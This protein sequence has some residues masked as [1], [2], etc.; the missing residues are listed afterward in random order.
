MVSILPAERTPYDV[1]GNMLGQDIRQNLPGAVA[2]GYQRGRGLSALD[3]AQA[4][5]AKNPNDPYAI[6]MAF[7]KAGAQNPE[8]SRALGPLAQTAMSQAAV[9]RAFPQGPGGQPSGGAP[10]VGGAPSAQGI[11]F[12]G[13]A[14]AGMPQA[15]SGAVEA[16]T[17]QAQPSAFATP[18]PFNILTPG[19]IEAESKRYAAAVQDPNAFATRQAMLQNQNQEAGIQRQNLEQMALNAKVP[20]DELPRFMLVGSKFDTR[21]P[22][23]WAQKTKQAYKTVKS[24]DD[25]IEK[26]FIPGLGS[27][28]LGRNRDEALKRLEPTVK[29]QIRL[30]LEGD[31][32]EKLAENYLSPTEIEGLVHPIQTRTEKAVEKLPK[33][34]FLV[35]KPSPYDM[36]GFPEQPKVSYEEMLEKNP[37]RLQKSQ[38]ELKNFFIKNVNPDTSLLVLREKLWKDKGYDW[39]QIGP[40]IRKAED[41][42]LKLSQSQSTEMSDIETQPPV[43]SLPD[44]FMDWGRVVQ[45]LRGNK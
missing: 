41:E 37:E 26:A 14:P 2:Q 17:P 44:I 33:G 43:Q 18:S 3:Q 6:A 30:G 29:D 24:N 1:I 34:D 36:W 25:K 20:A 7:A 12:G 10:A 4:E 15:P 11:S 40:A 19:D 8:L 13:Q 9:N 28:L 21:N 5:I 42:G 38:E 27:A 32:R 23:E 22:A 39:R 45:Y 35:G 31:V 16:A